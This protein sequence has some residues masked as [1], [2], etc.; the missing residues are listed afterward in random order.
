[1]IDQYIELGY[2]IAVALSFICTGATIFAKLT[3]TQKDDEVIA[4]IHKFVKSIADLKRPE[5]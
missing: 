3:E 5:K 2:Q 1:M 4:K